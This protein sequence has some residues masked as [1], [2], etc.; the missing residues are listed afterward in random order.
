MVRTALDQLHADVKNIDDLHAWLLEHHPRD[1]PEASWGV[2]TWGTLGRISSATR[3]GLVS[4]DTTLDHIHVGRPKYIHWS[5]GAYVLTLGCMG[6]RG[7]ECQDR[8]EVLSGREVDGV[9][10]CDVCGDY[11]A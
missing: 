6:A 7:E 8:G 9:E 3:E 2:P 10:V 1:A 4:W 11:H 5:G